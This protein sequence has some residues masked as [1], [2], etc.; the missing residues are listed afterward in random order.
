MA[1]SE[2]TETEVCQPTTILENT[3][4]MNAAFTQPEW[5]LTYVRSATQRR[6]GVG[7]L[8]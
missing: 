2:R 6:L 7:A 5:V 3:S 8:N 4:M 1:K